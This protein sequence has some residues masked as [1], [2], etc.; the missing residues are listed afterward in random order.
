MNFMNELIKTID[1]WNKDPIEDEWLFETFREQYVGTMSPSEAFQAI[2][3]TIDVLINLSD[4]ST[5]VE[6]LET[7]IDLAR[8]SDTTQVPAK[9][10]KTRAALI[11]QFKGMDDYARD[12]LG[13]LF[14]YYRF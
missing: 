6:V 5:A 3:C 14:Q 9:L 4:E 1:E 10:S 7:I 2:D 8:Q 13:E 12:K 11:N